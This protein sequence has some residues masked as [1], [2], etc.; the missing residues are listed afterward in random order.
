MTNPA[1]CGQAA[2]FRPREESPGICVGKRCI[3]E[4]KAGIEGEQGFWHRFVEILRRCVGRANVFEDAPLAVI[5]GPMVVV[6]F[7]RY[8]SKRSTLQVCTRADVAQIDAA[9]YY[10]SPFGDVGKRLSVT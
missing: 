6:N 4:H 1:L 8:S 5:L 7:G 9:L 2:A 10:G 3:H